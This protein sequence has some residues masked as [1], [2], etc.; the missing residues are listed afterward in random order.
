ML[1]DIFKGNQAPFFSSDSYIVE[2]YP[3]EAALYYGIVFLNGMNYTFKSKIS[4]EQLNSIIESAFVHTSTN[5]KTLTEIVSHFFEC[6]K[7]VEVMC[8]ILGL[9]YDIFESFFELTMNIKDDTKIY[10]ILQK[11]SKKK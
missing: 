7:G 1:I 3:K 9:D 10:N 8:N 11:L 6:N 5:S 4:Y 2:N